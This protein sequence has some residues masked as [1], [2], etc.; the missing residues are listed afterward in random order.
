MGLKRKGVKFLDLITSKAGYINEWIIVRES[1]TSPDY[2]VY[3]M[4]ES[5]TDHVEFGVIN[6]DK[7]TRTYK[8]MSCSLD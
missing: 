2:G 6:L 3:H 8:S 1:D 7:P 4:K 5:Q